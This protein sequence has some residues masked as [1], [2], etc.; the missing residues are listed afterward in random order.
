M[1]RRFIYL[2]SLVLYR[3][4]GMRLPHTFWPLGDVF[5]SVRRALLL[6]MGCSVGS[7]CE[8]EPH[9]DVGFSPRLRI[10]N[11][12]QINQNVAMKSAVIGDNVMIAPGVVFLDRLHRFN[13]VDIPM[14]LQGETERLI[15]EIGSDVWIGQNVIV[16]PGIRIGEGAIVGAGSVVTKD[17]AAWSIVVGVPARFLRSRHGEL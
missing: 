14:A 11:R 2:L 9:V 6:G 4:V 10:G 15:T 7:G 3:S 1:I 17:V 12:C 13:R 8:I 16:M 5:S